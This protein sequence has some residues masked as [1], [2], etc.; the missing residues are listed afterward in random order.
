MIDKIEAGKRFEQCMDNANVTNTEL[1][2][3]LD[4]NKNAVGNFKNGILPHAD[5]LYYISNY[6]GTT[7][8]YLLTGKEAAELAPNEQELIDLYRNTNDIGQPLI[9]NHAKDIQKA[10]PRQQEIKPEIISSDSKIG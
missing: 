10:L 4:L 8:E 6:L 1:T 9:T 2:K 3:A 5:T 7:V